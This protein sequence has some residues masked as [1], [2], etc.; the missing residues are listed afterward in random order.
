M[1]GIELDDDGSTG[2]GEGTAGGGGDD[3]FENPFGDLGFPVEALEGMLA[4]EFGREAF[5]QGF[6]ESGDVTVEQALCLLENIEVSVLLGMAGGG[7]P[8]GEAMVALFEAFDSCG[9]EASSI[10]G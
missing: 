5:A 1:C 2:G 6:A 8:D 9:I 3:D 10:I 4:T 7:E